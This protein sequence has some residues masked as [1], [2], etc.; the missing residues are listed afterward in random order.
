MVAKKN[1]NEFVVPLTEMNDH[2]DSSVL[3]AATLAVPLLA[4][5]SA[6]SSSCREI[7]GSKSGKHAE[8]VKVNRLMSFL[9]GSLV[10]VFM[11]LISVVIFTTMVMHRG[12]PTTFV[13]PYHRGAIPAQEDV[14]LM[15]PQG[16]ST[17]PYH[18]EPF[19]GQIFEILVWF[20][21]HLS[22]AVYL[23]I[24]FAM[25]TLAISK[26][27]WRCIS[28]SLSLK[29]TRRTCFLKT[30]FFINGFVQGSLMP[31]IFLELYIGNP[32]FDVYWMPT[33][34]LI[35]FF[36]VIYIYDWMAD[37]APLSHGVDEVDEDD[38]DGT[39]YLV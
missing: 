35:V 11:Q 33:T 26:V 32:S 6:T 14:T 5:E 30:F 12:V 3:I 37:S 1:P 18:K 10:G 7:D 34:H 13:D 8:Q 16:I 17:E 24:W 19:H 20:V 31:W 22:L 9:L 21:Y 29:S 39:N 4:A 25:M 38:D 27:G 2:G 15:S 23:I 28:T 36:A